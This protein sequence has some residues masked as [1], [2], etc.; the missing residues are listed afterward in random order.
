M[1]NRLLIKN[2]IVITLG[3]NNKIITDG[4]IIIENGIIQQVGKSKEII[5][6][7]SFDEVINANGMLI[8]PGFINQHMH[9]YSTF[10]RGIMPKQP[11]A[12]NFVEILEKL[13]WPLDKA[14]NENDLYYSAIV[15]I[16]NGIRS[17]TTTI[18][19]HHESQGLQDG[20]LD[21]IEQAIIETGIRGN[22]C[23]GISDRYNK[24]NVGIKE[25][26]R[27]IKKLNNYKKNDKLIT[28]MFGL[29]AAFTVN[30][31]TLLESAEAA[32]DLGVG[33]HIHVSEDL[34]DQKIN[35]NK[36]NQTVIKRLY[37]AKC[38]GPKSMA[39]HCIYLSDEEINI[40][41]NTETSIVHIPQS[42]MN[43]AV[44]VAD[45]GKMLNKNILCGIGTDGMSAGIQNDVRTA[46]ILHKLNKK[47]PRIFFCESCELALKNN[48]LISNKIL[49]NKIGVLEKD[50]CADIIMIDYNAPTPLNE[51]TFFGHF[52]FGICE[53]I[54]DT[55]IV[56]GKILMQNK[57]I[58]CVDEK[59]IFAASCK[60]AENF[61]KR[62]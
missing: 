21:L 4:A 34:A 17:G 57:E 10:A 12:K 53:A 48:S 25:N 28:A 24:G 41:K 46:N 6:D 11:P 35:Q 29:H 47:D 61:W 40:L 26:I 44:G 20:S 2:G 23:L 52:L 19:D 14:L 32:N 5:D 39:I 36:Y 50:Y 16:I 30:E 45:I 54:V 3:L 58:K 22:L 33:F 27:F 31:N 43:N 56:N 51:S 18:F 8:M 13:W 1:N 38:L 59:S 62:F 42:N 15:P 49:P 60:Q 55:T 37:N 7:K 9:F